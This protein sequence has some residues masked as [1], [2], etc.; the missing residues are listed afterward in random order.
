MLVHCKKGVKGHHK[1]K[2][3]LNVQSLSAAIS[4]STLPCS[5]SVSAAG[6][7]LSG[8]TG[9]GGASV[10]ASMLVSS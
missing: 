9:V 4:S 5:G 1:S 10:S 6:S 3:Y 7:L 8:L 2:H